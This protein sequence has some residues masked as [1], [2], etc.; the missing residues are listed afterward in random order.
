[1]SKL[2]PVGSGTTRCP[3]RIPAAGLKERHH[4][5]R[6]RSDALY[7]DFCTRFGVDTAA[8]ETEAAFSQNLTSLCQIVAITHGE[9]VSLY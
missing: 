3:L 5:I 9:S 4:I 8:H 7:R 1:M 6:V 2:A